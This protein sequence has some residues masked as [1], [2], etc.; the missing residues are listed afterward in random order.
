MNPQMLDQIIED[1]ISKNVFSGAQ[2]VVYHHRKRVLNR[3]YGT[4][5]FGKGAAE[6]H[7]D[8]LFDLASLTKPLAISSAF[9][10]LV[11]QKEVTLDDPAS[12]F[13]PG[14]ARGPKRQITL[15]RLLQH[16][17]GFPPWKP[18]YETIVRADDP[19]AALIDAVIKEELI[20]EPGSKQVY[21][22]LDFMLL[23]KI[24]EK[25]A[26]QRLDYFCE[27]SIFSPLS[28]DALYYLPIGAKDNIQKIRDRHVIVTEK[29]ERRGLLAG[30]VHDDNAHAAGGVCGHAGLFGSALAVGRLMIEW[31]AA[32]DG[33]GDLLSPKVVRE[34]VF[35][36]DMPPQA[37]W[38]LGWDR[39]TWRVSQAGR[40]ISPHAIGHLGFTGTAAWLDHQRH[41]LIV[42]NTNR[43]HPS[44]Q[45]RRLPDFR[46]AVHNAVFE[47]LDA[48]APGPYTPPPE[49]SKVKS[50]H[51]IGIAGTGMAS[52]AGM[53]KQSGYSVSGSDQAV[54][55]PMSK[56]LEK[57]K[58]TV[59]QPFAETNINRPDL[60][61]VGNA[62]TRDHVEAAAAQRRRLAY[63]SMP[64]VLE[65]FFLVKKT[66]LVVA[67]THGKTTTSA[68][69][70]WLL[71]SAGYDPS[72]MIGG[73]VNN[74][75]SNYKLGKGGFFV[76]EGDE[77]DSAYFDKYPKFMH[78][79]PKGAIVTSIEYDHADIYEDVE[80]IE[81]RFKQFAA[82]AP[83]DG[84]LVA[85]WDGDAVRRVAK[86]ARGQV[87]TYGE[88]PDAQWRAADLRVEDGKTRF[89]LKRRKERIAE[90][91]LPMVGRQNVW[92]A[93]A[94]C[95]LLLAFDFPPDKLA[96]GFAEF[97]G[98][99]RRQ[100][101]V[102][103]TAGVRVIDDF[104]HHPTAVA[105][106][107]EGLR[108]QYPAG[109]LLVAFDPRTNT[110]SRRVFQDRLAVCFKGADIVAV[111]QPSRLD[112]IPP[113]QRLDVDKLVRD[114]AAGG[115]EAKHLAAV[116]DMAK[117]L[118]SKA[119]RG[120]TIAVL[121]NGGF[122]GL[123]EKLLKQLKA[124][125]K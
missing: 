64:G 65:R 89:T 10:L 103:E 75:G 51:F 18:Y 15:R 35:P 16:S 54:Y 66:P 12:R 29:C 34:F 77:Y 62:C 74:F 58:I 67:G 84:H 53:L 33:E 19:R 3:A 87:H 120:D 28:I 71:Q 56:L 7:D 107:L 9:A 48:V 68:M 23:G 83:P 72:F 119:R 59:K 98:V 60:V 95:A 30:E 111:G 41:V 43:V 104:A 45:E 112:R 32:L 108:L 55:P 93:V 114:L 90:I 40:H 80:E 97:Q 42:L 117:W 106:T 6:V 61:V 69:V 36:R 109:R 78:Y 4:T 94:A 92:D 11:D 17:A 27:D 113:E 82:L 52:L 88:H 47:M 38:A 20:Y 50:I 57:L 121:S 70:A 96:R 101:L 125:K 39:P 91:V 14:L 24:V 5:R 46:R 124:K 37:G 76:V 49:P 25:V 110:T 116:D 115:L 22:D 81:A 21:S 102:G 2:F 100:T 105:A 79:R 44:R 123:Q 13:L 122:G 85:C 63:D 86:A 26:G 73:L 1:A 31:E 8:S 118:V 99:A